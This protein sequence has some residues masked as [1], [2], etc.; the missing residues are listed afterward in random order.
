MGRPSNRGMEQVDN[1]QESNCSNY[2]H[3]AIYIRLSYES[4]YTDSESIENQK[5]LLED[6]LQKHKEFVLCEEYIDDGKTGTNFE[7]P[8]FERMMKAV[9][10]GAINCIVV[11]DVS[12]FGR[13]HVEVGDYIER[14]FPYL[15]VRFVSINDGYDS[16]NPACDKDQ[17]LLSVKN[18]MH[19]MYARD[20]SKKISSSIKIKQKTGEFYRTAIIPYGYK[21]GASEYEIDEQAAAVVRR[22]FHSFASGD[23]VYHICDV[24]NHE[25]VASPREYATNTSLYSSE[26]ADTCWIAS[27]VKRMLI[28][29]VY[30]GNMVRHKRE[31][32]FYNNKEATEVEK[33]D[34]IRVEN[35][36]PAIIDQTVFK[37]VQSKFIQ[38]KS[39]QSK[40]IHSKSRE[41]R[42]VDAPTS[43]RKYSYGENIFKNKIFCGECKA[44]M[45]RVNVE[46]SVNKETFIYKGFS[47]GLHRN[48][49]NKCTHKEIIEEDVLCNL[50]N[51]IVVDQANLYKGILSLIRRNGE[52]VFNND[53]ILINSDRK[54]I[55]ATIKKY[56]EKRFDALEEYHQGKINKSQVI[57]RRC[58]IQNLIIKCNEREGLLE[59]RLLK[60]GELE[61]TYGD[62]MN[63][64]LRYTQNPKITKEVIGLFVER[65]E[66]H[67][68]KRVV[69]KLNHID[70]VKRIIEFACLADKGGGNNG[71]NSNIPEV[72]KRG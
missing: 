6:F 53:R 71:S 61:N 46:K 20:V 12:R 15:G 49:I 11:K 43:Q 29:E 34:W 68:Q 63:S 38:G 3:T 1:E 21:M 56:E 36:H 50:I 8:A 24:L 37:Q 59:E 69:I 23:T 67:S 66:V 4:Y 27:T 31:Q 22:V 17:L 18:L 60:V 39:I 9:K 28:N 54:D 41:S 10:E 62:L 55:I 58:E 35:T 72:I 2:F 26:N 33:K 5:L 65:I 44:I 45:T 52:D 25:G 42:K 16:F 57:M 30:I 40:S 64:W 48:F 70:Y 32:E 7:R 13:N 47:C 51:R 19:E 14:I